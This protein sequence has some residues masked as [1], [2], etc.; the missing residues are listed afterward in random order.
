MYAARLRAIGE[1]RLE[2]VHR[3]V[4]RPGEVLVRV[5][6][7]GICGSD[8]HMFRGEYPTALPVT[9]GHEFC[10]IV[11]AQGEGATRIRPG[12]RVTCDPN[13]AC[14]HCPA[15]RAGRPNLCHNL[16]AIGVFRDGGFAE[17][18]A[19]PEMQ[20]FE[21]P[22]DLD[23]VH[24]AFSEPLACC[25]HGLDVARIQPGG[26]VAIL[27]GGVIGLLMVQLARLAGATTIVLATRQAPRR[28]L[29]L[30]TGASHAIDP[31][32]GDPVGTIR[33]RH[34][35]LNDVNVGG[36][37]VVRMIDEFPIF[38]VAALF[39]EGMTTVRDAQELRVKETDRLAVMTAELTKLGAKITET[40]DGFVIKGA[41]TLTGATV[42]G[43]DD[44]RLSMSLVVAGL[45]A[46]L[47][48]LR[49][50]VHA[51]GVGQMTPLG[52][53][54]PADLA[55]VLAAKVG[56]AVVLDEVLADRELD[57]FVMFSSVA[58]VWGSGGQSA[59]AAAN[60]FL[61]GLAAHRRAAQAGAE[62]I[63][64]RAA[65]ARLERRFARGR[66]ARAAAAG[67][68]LPRHARL[69]RH[70]AAHARSGARVFADR[71]QQ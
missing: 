20:A 63:S 58:G 67:A 38:M 69:S 7:A 12:T 44:H 25:L 31:E 66:G 51:A 29:A 56:G 27:G 61:D 46:G 68:R 45:V 42:D 2:T 39:A 11:E 3:P 9:L 47:P 4:P 70:A 36:E 23:P 17:H 49:G 65:N 60:A 18:V 35:T 16:V 30:E 53:S 28:A 71:I 54:G 50:V 26:S 1:M 55:R 64:F 57:F 10:G 41:Q 62:Q 15:C 14:G 37:V 8:R 5:E 22:D 40:A 21:L 13:I 19:I 34:S 52:A 48:G 24:G 59:Y 33:V 43:H 32:A 6:A